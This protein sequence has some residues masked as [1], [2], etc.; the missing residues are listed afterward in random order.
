MKFN[1]QLDEIPQ[2]ATVAVADKVLKLKAAGKKIT[3]LQVGDPDFQTPQGIV[4]AAAEALQSGLTH[5]GPS[6][7]FSDLR[8]AIAEHIQD[9]AGDTEPVGVYDP[10][11]EILVTHGGVHAYYVAMQS[12]LNPGDEVLIPDP[13]WATH[14][15]MVRL[16][17]GTPIPVPASPENGFLPRMEVLGGRNNTKNQSDGD[18]LP[19]KPDWRSSIQ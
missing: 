12:I 16:L 7:G 15:N 4:D 18:Q 14:T 8:G 5:Y 2:S 6:R 17:R 3:P 13:S 11:R 1:I 10:D 9:R 19:F